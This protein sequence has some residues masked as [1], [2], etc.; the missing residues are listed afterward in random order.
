MMQSLKLRVGPI[1]EPARNHKPD[2]L[3]L[4]YKGYR[5]FKSIISRTKYTPS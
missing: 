4:T 2:F 1:T 3:F 5:F